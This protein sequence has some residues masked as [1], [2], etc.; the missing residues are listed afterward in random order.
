METNHQIICYTNY[1]G[2][3]NLNEIGLTQ[4]ELSVW[5]KNPNGLYFYFVRFRNN[6]EHISNQ[7]IELAKQIDNFYL[8]LDDTEEGYAY[9]S[10][11]NVYEFTNKHQLFNKIIYASGHYEV[12]KV[13]DYWL[14]TKRC[15]SIF[16]VWSHNLWYHRMRDWVNDCEIPVKYQKNM[17]YCSMNNRPRLHR[18]FAIAY[19]DVLGILEDGIVTA[20]DRN[21]ES[22]SNDNFEDTILSR[23]PEI[24]IDYQNII[25]Q[26]VSITGK[27]LPLVVD[28]VDLANKSLPNDLHPKVYDNTL[29]NLVTETYYFPE[30]NFIDETFITEKSWKVFTAGQLP[31]IIGPRGIV[32]RLRLLGF[33]MFDD[34]IDHSYD[35]TDD[36]VRVFKA[37]ESMHKLMSTHNIQ[38]LNLITQKRRLLNRKKFLFGI[39]NLD[40]PLREVLCT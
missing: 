1:T 4:Q 16:Y 17:W 22:Y 33:D 2:I 34:I 18:L 27:K 40:I 21:Y 8:V 15:P 32:S 7:L 13:Y 11:S 5:Q 10:F 29:I 20:N 38:Q 3:N 12:K 23:V 24:H 37:I 6:P 26:R 39:K 31:V 30:Y 28:S 25:K 19:L 14:D 35:N 36:S 9:Y